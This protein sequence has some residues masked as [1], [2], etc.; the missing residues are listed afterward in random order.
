MVLHSDFELIQH[1]WFFTRVDFLLI[2]YICFSALSTMTGSLGQATYSSANAFLDANSFCCLPLCPH[3]AASALMWGAV[4]YIGMRWTSFA[5]E[6]VLAR[7]EQTLDC[8]N[9]MKAGYN[10]DADSD[11]QMH[12]QFLLCS[13][14]SIGELAHSLLVCS[15]HVL[16]CAVATSSQNTRYSLQCV[17]VSLS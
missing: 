8:S 7:S 17:D 15:K 11:W 3:I 12:V 5:S 14:A 2:S 1:H 16:F 10:V 4:G 9:A 6:D 13:A